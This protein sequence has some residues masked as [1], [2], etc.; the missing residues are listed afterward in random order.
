MKNRPSDEEYCTIL[1]ALIRGI[2][3]WWAGRIAATLGWKLTVRIFAPSQKVCIPLVQFMKSLY[4][5]QLQWFILGV[6]RLS[7]NLNQPIF[8]CLF[9]FVLL[10]L[11]KIQLKHPYTTPPP[12]QYV[13]T[14]YSL[15]SRGFLFYTRDYA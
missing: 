15:Q 8:T 12:Q 13:F 10:F 7:Q 14:R 3:C 5:H 2:E 4:E 1:A 6:L 9:S 11:S